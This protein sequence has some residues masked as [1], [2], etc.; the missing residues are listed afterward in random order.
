MTSF[1]LDT[2]NQL[3]GRGAIVHIYVKRGNT[4]SQCLPQGNMQHSESRGNTTC[5]KSSEKRGKTG[6]R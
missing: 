5:K 3:W 6:I 2:K 4:R 1:E